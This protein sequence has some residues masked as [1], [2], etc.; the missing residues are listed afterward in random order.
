MVRTMGY[1]PPPTPPTRDVISLPTPDRSLPITLYIVDVCL[2]SLDEDL[3]DNAG[4]QR[5]IV[6]V[7][8]L[9]ILWN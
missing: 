1:P 7:K 9:S 3:L 6:W 4:S 5:C 2:D 8:Q